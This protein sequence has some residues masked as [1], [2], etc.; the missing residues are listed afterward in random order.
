M[1]SL[2]VYAPFFR[3]FGSHSKIVRPLQVKNPRLISI[4]NNVTIND[5]VFMIAE[6]SD[7]KGDDSLLCVGDGTTMGHFNHVVAVNKVLIGRNVL[8]AD[9]VYLSD[10]YHGFEDVNLPISWQ[11]VKSK[12]STII[13][14]ETWLGENVCVISASIGKHCIVAANSVVI[15]DIPD[16]SMAA[17]VPAVV[18]K[19]YNF[20]K[21]IWEKC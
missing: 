17:G 4:G 2:I 15:S 18:K 10:N 9:R 12:A 11:S 1:V 8:T 14:D 20:E 6:P 16:F 7:Q 13:G 19:R 5:G 3:S 21:K